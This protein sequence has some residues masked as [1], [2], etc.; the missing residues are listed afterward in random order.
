MTEPLSIY[1]H[2]PWCQ[3]KCPYCDFNSHAAEAVE[4]E[5]WRAA[6]ITELEHFTADI[7]G[8]PVTSIFF[9]G[10]TPSLM[11]PRT[12]RAIINFINFRM[13]LEENA[14][15]TLEAN[16]TSSEAEKFADLA[17]AGV[18]RLSLGVQ[19]FDD[20]ALQFLGRTHDSAQAMSA[21]KAASAKFPRF[22]LDLIYAR[23]GQ[24]ARAWRAEL[25]RALGFS[26]GHL[27]AYQLTIEPGTQFFDERIAIADDEAAL[28]LYEITQKTLSSAGLLA[29][30]VS[31]H[32]KPGQECRHNLSIWRGGDYIG[33]GP[34][35]HGRLSGPSGCESTRQIL[36]PARWLAQI[37]EK[38]HGTQA[39]NAISS[40]ERAEELLI[41][42]LRTSLGVEKAR[43][44]EKCGLSVDKTI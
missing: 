19:S 40:R 20:A 31:N 16:P 13:T 8:R 14:E 24:S 9:G 35:A 33:A 34:G 21:I 3:S 37:E 32:A 1:I 42:G 17:A 25:D 4:Q 6:I 28:E 36:D 44:F 22:S 7:A 38:G 18:N 15:I 39:R 26:P 30:E 5:R 27:S 41:L 10:G 11:D 2:W 12:V 43:F 23:S 29:Y